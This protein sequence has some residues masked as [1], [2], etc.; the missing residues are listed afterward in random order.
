MIRFIGTFFV[1]ALSFYCKGQIVNSFVVDGIKCE[2][3]EPY[4]GGPIEVKASIGVDMQEDGSYFQYPLNTLDEL[5]LPSS[6]E[7]QGERYVIDGYL[8]IANQLEAKA[9]IFPNSVKGGGYVIRCPKLEKIDYAMCT[10]VTGPAYDLENL[11]ELVFSGNEIMTIGTHTF[12]HLFLESWKVPAQ[13][14]RI[15]RDSFYDWP[16]LQYLDLDNVM[17]LGDGTILN[18]PSLKTL[19]MPS[20]IHCLDYTCAWLPSLEKL[21]LP[22]FFRM[23][24]EPYQG[25]AYELLNCL[26]NC[27]PAQIYCRSQLPPSVKVGYRDTFCDETEYIYVGQDMGVNVEACTVYVPVGC[28]EAYASHP[29]WSA[30]PNI[31]EVD[32]AQASIEDIIDSNPANDIVV[33]VS[34]GRIFINGSDAVKVYDMQGVPVV[35]GSLLPGIYV[36][37]DGDGRSVKL[38]VK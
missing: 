3:Y 9:I 17:Y 6:L 4:E 7:Y 32:Y 31:V 26:T 19:I 30:F 11:R 34:D 16:I 5:I 20:E 14:Q 35:N 33:K 24:A 28:K 23:P 27:A 8:T 38:A 15:A 12:T 37:N 10:K 29:S 36:A 21:V 22:E 2:L 13:F 18:M 25:A 1:M